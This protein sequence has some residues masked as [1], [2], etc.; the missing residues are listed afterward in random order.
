SAPSRMIP[1]VSGRDVPA[2]TSGRPAAEPGSSPI[3]TAVACRGPDARRVITRRSGVTSAT[4]GSSRRESTNDA[5]TK[6]DALMKFVVFTCA[7]HASTGR[8]ATHPFDS[9]RTPLYSATRKS[10]RTTAIPTPAMVIA[11]RVASHAII[12]RVSGT[13]P[14]GSHR[15]RR[16]AVGVDPSATGGFMRA[17]ERAWLGIAKPSGTPPQLVVCGVR[18]DD[19]DPQRRELAEP[20]RERVVRILAQ[21]AFHA[22]RDLGGRLAQRLRGQDQ[23]VPGRCAIL[24]PTQRRHGGGCVEAPERAQRLGHEGFAELLATEIAHLSRSPE[25]A[26]RRSRHEMPRA[27]DEIS[28]A[29]PPE[30]A[31]VG[32]DD[33]ITLPAHQLV[34]AP[35]GARLVEEFE[36]VRGDGERARLADGHGDDRFRREQSLGLHEHAGEARGEVGRDPSPTGRSG[37]LPPAT[38]NLQT[39]PPARPV[40]RADAAQFRGTRAIGPGAPCA[41]RR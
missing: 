30:A 5:G 25:E 35:D 12:P 41:A 40:G 22:P 14:P 13:P 6:D 39:G 36:V 15:A 1:P 31:A 10:M 28:Q 8:D 34:R 38:H 23:L 2:I 4:P 26:E 11:K 17:D 18:L 24:P 32:D 16:R 33:L 9:V 29:V 37:L 3:T 27:L 7:T 19:H 20:A 21:R